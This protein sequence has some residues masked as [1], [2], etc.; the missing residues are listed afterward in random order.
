MFCQSIDVPAI[1]FDGAHHRFGAF[2][3]VQSVLA[4]GHVDAGHQALQVPLPRADGD[5]IEIVQVEDDVALRRTVK[6]EVVDV[7][8]A[9]HDHL[10]AGGRGF[11]EVPRHDARGATQET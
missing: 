7:R 1:A 5:L 10:D 11:G 3:L 9:A 6:P 2:F 8:I 4:R